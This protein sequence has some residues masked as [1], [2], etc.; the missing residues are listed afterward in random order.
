MYALRAPPPENLLRG[1]L[2]WRSAR[3][4]EGPSPPALG[5][6]VIYVSIYDDV[7]L[8]DATIGK[9]SG[10]SNPTAAFGSRQWW[11]TI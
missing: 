6:G 8:L 11:E 3:I 5:D 7:I 4:G 1:E 2:L 9:P 10:A